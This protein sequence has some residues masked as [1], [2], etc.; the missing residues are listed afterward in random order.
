MKRFLLLI[1]V[2][3]GAGIAVYHHQTGRLPWAALSAEEEQVLALKEELAQIRQ[4]WV[5]AGRAAALGVDGG[6]ADGPLGR[7]DRLERSLAALDATLKTP[8]ARNLAGALRRDMKVFR[9]ELR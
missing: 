7:L 6:Q 9:S 1:L 3:A 2:L 4:Q 8:E 5:A